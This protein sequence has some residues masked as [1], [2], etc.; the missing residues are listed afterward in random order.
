MLR[1][2]ACELMARRFEVDI[3]LSGSVSESCLELSPWLSDVWAV[4]LACRVA[5]VLQE[6]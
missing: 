3:S 2:I 6:L 5:G 1:N 4:R